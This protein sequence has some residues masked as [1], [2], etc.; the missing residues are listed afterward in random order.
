MAI[1]RRVSNIVASALSVARA[2]GDEL[3]RAASQGV[4][5][6]MDMLDAQLE[7][8]AKAKADLD[9]RD[10]S[11]RASSF[12]ANSRRRAETVENAQEL[13]SRARASQLRKEVDVASA[14]L[15]ESLA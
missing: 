6:K 1:V 2:K 4:D 7:Y 9:R 13:S 14:K 3:R 5:R 12:E 8:V 15:R 10:A 11:L